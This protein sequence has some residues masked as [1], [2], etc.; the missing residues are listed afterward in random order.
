MQEYFSKHSRK[1]K[2]S[3]EETDEEGKTRGLSMEI[4]KDGTKERS[5]DGLSQPNK[6][7]IFINIY[8]VV[9]C[10]I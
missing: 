3:D 2:N 7:A 8:N 5:P 10:K 9:F 4:S 1:K 6:N